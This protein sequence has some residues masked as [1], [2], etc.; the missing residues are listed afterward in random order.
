MKNPS[1]QRQYGPYEAVGQLMPTYSYHPDVNLVAEWPS[2]NSLTLPPGSNGPVVSVWMTCPKANLWS[3]RTD[4]AGVVV[5]AESH[6]CVPV[7]KLGRSR[8]WPHMVSEGVE[9]CLSID[10]GCGFFVLCLLEP[11][12]FWAAGALTAQPVCSANGADRM[13][14][15]RGS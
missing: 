11:V 4:N 2:R 14:I 6:G 10:A 15:R 12:P 3:A 9:S 1:R 13:Q 7:H 8:N 5:T